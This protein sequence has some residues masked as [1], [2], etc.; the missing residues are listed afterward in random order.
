[1]RSSGKAAWTTNQF[2]QVLSQ[3]LECCSR[4]ITPHPSSPY[5]FRL[6]RIQ[7]G[8][9]A[10]EKHSSDHSQQSSCK[11]D[12]ETMVRQ[13]HHMVQHDAPLGDSSPAPLFLRCVLC[14]LLHPKGVGY[15]RF[16]PY[17]GKVVRDRNDTF[18]EQ[19]S[20]YLSVLNQD[21]QS[22]GTKYWVRHL[23]NCLRLC[24]T[25]YLETRSLKC[26]RNGH[27]TDTWRRERCREVEPAG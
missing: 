3:S 22:G 13:A 11:G 7:K 10:R 17:S 9:R 21:S 18:A 14:T 4:K 27:G 1:M 16:I 19:A 23:G 20:G 24:C 12:A 5:P 25:G 6:S 15:W 8:R 26:E 2:F